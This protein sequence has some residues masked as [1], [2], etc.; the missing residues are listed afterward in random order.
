MENV[1]YL[2]YAE[3]RTLQ[4]FSEQQL[5]YTSEPAKRKYIQNWSAYN[6][7]QT[8]EKFMSLKILHEVIESVGIKTYGKSRGR[9][10]FELKDMIKCC[11]IKVFNGFSAR[12]TIP[13]LEIAHILRYISKKPH[14]NSIINYMN[15]PYITPFLK[16]IIKKLS[17]PLAPYEKR[18]AIDATGFSTFNKDKW[19]KVRLQHKKHRDY[20]KLHAIC[21]VYTNIIISAKVTDG[22]E[23]DSPH[24]KELLHNI[25]NNFKIKEVSADAG[26][27]SRDN[28]A[29]VEEIGAKP[30]IMPKKN[31]KTTRGS[32]SAWGRMVRLFQ[33]NES[34][35]RIHYHQRSNI[36]SSFAMIKRKFGDF[37]R[38]KHSKAQENEIL[39]KVICHNLSVLVST[40]F[41]LGL[42]LEY[43]Q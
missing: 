37:V 41:E 24:F 31:T 6:Q 32:L 34:K 10:P 25:A 4:N 23:A 28:A 7:A 18:F 16:G 3:Q 1:I 33:Q 43:L 40:V 20:K 29:A 26:Y 15:N 5:D 30:F 11:C 27:L 8:K 39:C 21:G 19:V 22:R 13:E 2:P 42:D 38:S 14:F 36:E 35:F 12:R 17:I 9:P